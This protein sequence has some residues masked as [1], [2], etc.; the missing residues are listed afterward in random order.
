MRNAEKSD[1]N[2]EKDPSLVKVLAVGPSIQVDYNIYIANVQALGYS[3]GLSAFSII[4]QVLSQ[5]T[6]SGD[7]S[8]KLQE[9]AMQQNMTAF[10]NVTSSKLL[11][12]QPKIITI[13]DNRV[14][15]R[16]NGNSGNRLSEVSVIIIIVVVVVVGILTIVVGIMWWFK[17]EMF[18]TS[19]EK[20]LDLDERIEDGKIRAKNGHLVEIDSDQSQ[21]LNNS[22]ASSGFKVAIVNDEIQQ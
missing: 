16:D 7:F 3:T 12:S 14:A 4:A 17:L 20:Y 15:P 13:R 19:R 1:I 18:K 5:A 11:F 10:L 2:K 22:I 9:L 6:T 21:Y 8:K